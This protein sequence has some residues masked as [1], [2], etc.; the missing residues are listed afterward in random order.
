METIRKSAYFHLKE[1]NFSHAAAALDLI[2][3]KNLYD[4][5]EVTVDFLAIKQLKVEW[6]TGSKVAAEFEERFPKIIESLVSGP[7]I[8][9]GSVKPVKGHV[10]GLREEVTNTLVQNNE[11][12]RFRQS[13][14]LN[15]I[16]DESEARTDFTSLLIIADYDVAALDVKAF[17]QT[18]TSHLTVSWTKNHPQAE[19]L[20][21]NLRDILKTELAPETKAK[22]FV[23]TVQSSRATQSDVAVRFE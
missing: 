5:L 15:N 10:F 14:V 22:S 11:Q 6:N 18:A 12:E 16:Y 19:K 3:S 23:K 8:Q 9:S 1:S 4:A 20:A 17:T 21:E 7:V 2:N 13:F